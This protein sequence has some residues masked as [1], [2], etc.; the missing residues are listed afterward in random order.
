ME[1]PA[2]RDTAAIPQSM[3]RALGSTAPPESRPVD[4]Q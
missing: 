3:P 4:F 1:Q 2:Q